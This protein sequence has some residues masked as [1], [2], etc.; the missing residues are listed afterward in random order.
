MY[1]NTHTHTQILISGTAKQ[2]LTTKPTDTVSCKL[3]KHEHSSKK[4]HT[5]YFSFW[6]RNSF[7]VFIIVSR[8]LVPNSLNREADIPSIPHTFTYKELLEQ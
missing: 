1:T 2:K 6:F 5:S 8:N 3:S 7:Y 4:F